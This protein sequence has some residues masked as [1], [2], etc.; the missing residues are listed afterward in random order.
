MKASATAIN[1]CISLQ[2]NVAFVFEALI[3]K[4]VRRLSKSHGHEWLRSLLVEGFK[5]ECGAIQKVQGAGNAS[6]DAALSQVAAI[7][8]DLSAAEHQS[9]PPHPKADPGTISTTHQVPHANGTVSFA[10]LRKVIG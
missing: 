2:L 6:R 3:L 4:R 5:R 1:Q 10:A 9:P 8:P 7:H